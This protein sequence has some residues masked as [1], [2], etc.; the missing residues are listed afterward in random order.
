[1]CLFINCYVERKMYTALRA[2]AQVPTFYE[3]MFSGFYINYS[4]L[5]GLQ[6]IFY[7]VIFLWKAF[8]SKKYIFYAFTVTYSNH[9]REKASICLPFVLSWTM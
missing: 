1:M 4:F 9:L 8:I 6:F 2:T 7:T 5:M 3:Q